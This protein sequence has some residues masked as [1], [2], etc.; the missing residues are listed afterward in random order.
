[1][2]HIIWAAK[3]VSTTMH[4]RDTLQDFLLIRDML[5]IFQNIGVGSVNELQ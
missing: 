3:N 4:D 2:A 1:M 5:N